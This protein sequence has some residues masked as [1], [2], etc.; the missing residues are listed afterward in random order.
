MNKIGTLALGMVMGG[1]GMSAYYMMMPKMKQKQIKKKL[2][3]L[4]SSITDV[5]S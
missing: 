5:N 3:N 4:A 1:M 2:S